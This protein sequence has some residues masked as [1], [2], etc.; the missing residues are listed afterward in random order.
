MS[1]T[2]RSRIAHFKSDCGPE[3]SGWSRV[4]PF[5]RIVLADFFYETAQMTYEIIETDNRPTDFFRLLNALNKS[6]TSDQAEAVGE[7][8]GISRAKVYRLL[9]MDPGGLYVLRTKK[10]HYEK[11]E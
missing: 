4:L 1:V 8:M 10:G 2:D 7:R 5:G 6:F 3:R 9:K 11:V